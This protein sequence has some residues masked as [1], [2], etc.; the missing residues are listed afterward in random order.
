MASDATVSDQ[1]IINAPAGTIFDLLADPARHGQ[2]DGSGTVLSGRSG[3]PDRL[4]QGATFS[5]SMK[6]GVPYRISNTVVEFDEDRRIAWRHMGRHVWRYDL[7][8]IDETTT[9]VTETFDWGPAVA[10]FLYPLVG[11]PERNLRAITKTLERLAEAV[12]EPPA[13]G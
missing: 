4:S 8:P 1:R 13:A 11:V 3:N 7:E 9:R 2:I 5:M 10:G 6:Q 12:E